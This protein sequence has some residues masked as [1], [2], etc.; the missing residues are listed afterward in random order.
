MD[1]ARAVSYIFED[2]KW[3]S[4]IVI[5]AVVS[6]LS[7][8]SL[9]VIGLPALAVAL[10]FVVQVALNVRQGSPRPLP[11]WNDYV[12]KFTL[13]G[14]VLLAMLV[15]NLP[16]L[17]IGS[18]SSI[19]VRGLGGGLFGQGVGFLTVCCTLPFLL[20]Y[21]A[22][23]WPMLATGLT[24]FIDTGE[25]GALYRPA[26]LWDVM[27]TH[28][29]TVIQWSLYAV[30]VNLVLIVLL[31]IP[32]IGWLLIL[33]FGFPVHGHLLG[34]YAHQLSIPQE[35]KPKVKPSRA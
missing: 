1:L 7:L 5:L 30:L 21:T 3:V 25:S 12:N 17:L 8:T 27:R 10:G 15:Y 34:Q 14:Q 24:E 20:L 11:E 2:R 22:F 32:C 4:K 26:H 31:V 35:A 18:C 16:V 33:M 13:G 28:S 29:N 9:V 23:A 6:T 19:I